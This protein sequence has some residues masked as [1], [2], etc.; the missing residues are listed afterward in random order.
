MRILIADDHQVVR[1]GIRGFLERDGGV[2]V[3]GEAVDGRDA[4]AQAHRLAPDAILM[5]VC[6]PNL[7]GL[8]ATRELSRVLPHL[9]VI[10]LSQYDMAEMKRKA[11]SAGAYA[12]VVKSAILRDLGP[13]LDELRRTPA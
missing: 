12:Y 6:M 10:V 3:C 5:D 7:N 4:I 13:V 1:Q 9:P 2:E 8:D 11:L